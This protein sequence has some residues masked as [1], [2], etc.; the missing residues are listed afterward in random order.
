M[1]PISDITN[2][3]WAGFLILSA[4]KS[5]VNFWSSQ[6]AVSGD[7]VCDSDLQPSL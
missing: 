6:E 3:D 7:D 4:E 1:N 5:A 2:R